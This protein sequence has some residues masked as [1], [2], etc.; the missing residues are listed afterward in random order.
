MLCPF[1]DRRFGPE[2]VAG[3]E[4]QHCLTGSKPRRTALRSLTSL[5]HEGLAMIVGYMHYR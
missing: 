3:L 2:G 4:H 5:I 1:F